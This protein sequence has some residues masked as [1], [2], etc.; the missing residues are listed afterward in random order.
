MLTRRSLARPVLSGTKFS[1]NLFLNRSPDP[2]SPY[3]ELAVGASL[4]G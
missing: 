2:A 1:R 3:V 4:W